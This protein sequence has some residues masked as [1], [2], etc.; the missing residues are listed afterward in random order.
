MYIVLYF[1]HR[2]GKTKVLKMAIDLQLRQSMENKREKEEM[3]T[4]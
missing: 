2:P 4:T 1:V 3:Q